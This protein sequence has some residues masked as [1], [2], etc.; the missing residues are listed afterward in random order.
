MSAGIHSGRPSHLYWQLVPHWGT[1]IMVFIETSIFTRQILDLVSDD[2]LRAL[3]E[4]IATSP[5]AGKLI[6][7]SGGCRKLRWN[8]TATGKRGGIRV[9][10]YWMKDRD[11]VLLLLAYAKS[12]TVD[13]SQAQIKKLGEIVKLEIG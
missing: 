12:R 2:H 7:G 4:W 5:A 8:T 13:L 1:L 11:L 9:I 6:K 3:Q 10:Y